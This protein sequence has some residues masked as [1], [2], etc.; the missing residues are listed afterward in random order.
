MVH[1]VPETWHLF[2][3]RQ[4][5][6]HML[7][8]ICSTLV[9]S[10]EYVK[11]GL[12]GAAVQRALKR[13]NGGNH[14]RVHIRERGGCHASRERGSIQFVIGVQN[15]SDVQRPLGSLRWFGP[16]KHQQKIRRMRK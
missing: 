14:R 5:L 1:A 15:Q 4:H 13:P 2:L 16:V 12:V 3:L 10:L 6:P 8:R 9:D 7:D 11:H